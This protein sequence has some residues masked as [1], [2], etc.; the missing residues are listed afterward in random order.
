[1]STVHIGAFDLNLLS[2]FEALWAE[3]NVTRAAR[4]IGLSQ[5]ALSHALKRLR[6]QLADPLFEPSPGGMIPTPRAQ[7]LATPLADAMTLIRA[8]LEAPPP[9]AARRLKRSFTLATADYGELVILP[10]L[11][12]RIS[13]EAPDVT[14]LVRPLGD[15]P[16]RDLASGLH[17]LVLT[18]QLG[19]DP[20]L[21][22][23]PLFDDRFV[24][25]L[26]RGH[27]LA[28]RKLT[29]SR[30]VALLHV[31]VSPQG[32]GESA[33]DVALR[34]VGKTRRVAVRVPHFLVAPL[35]IAESDHV[36][37][38]PERLVEAMAPLRRLTV[39]PTPIA[40]PPFSIS[41]FWHE[42][43]DVDPAHRWL[44][45]LVAQVSSS[46]PSRS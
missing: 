19:A 37:T 42:R 10:R 13:R 7:A 40:V 33:V 4:R 23:A 2:A 41:Q 8:A 44:R 14:L 39:H 35:V 25:L 21:R 34:Q 22:S 28:R 6:E 15:H 17:D 24:C 36:I 26:R 32:A 16:E 9:F 45:E 5:S 31:L 30:Y 3:R 1:M 18:P 20:W 43:N 27:P 29:L 11:L 38:L 46:G 12:R